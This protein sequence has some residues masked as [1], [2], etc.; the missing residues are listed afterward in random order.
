M[1]V[2]NRKAVRETLQKEIFRACEAEKQ[3]IERISKRHETDKRMQKNC[4]RRRKEVAAQEEILK[5]LCS[6]DD[7]TVYEAEKILDD[8]KGIIKLVIQ[9]T[10]ISD[11]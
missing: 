1:T 4:E 9:N 6:I 11:C 2:S 5:I 8:A 3:K 7:M 10:L